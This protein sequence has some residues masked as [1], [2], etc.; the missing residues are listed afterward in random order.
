MLLV[1]TYQ[2]RADQEIILMCTQN[3]L[4]TILNANGLEQI[5]L[6]IFNKENSITVKVGMGR[7]I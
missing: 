1:A 7:E 3:V 5:K 2:Q 6:L 4:I